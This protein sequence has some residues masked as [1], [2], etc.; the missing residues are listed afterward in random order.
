MLF[1]TRI[2][3]AVLLLSMTACSSFHR[4]QQSGYGP[5]PGQVES[6]TPNYN[7]IPMQA[8]LQQ[9]ES[10]LETTREKQQYSKILP[11]FNS[12][13]EKIEF[14]SL[15]NLDERQRWIQANKIWR[16]SQAPS[17][18]VRSLIEGGDISVGMPMDYVKKSWGEPQNVEV[19][20]NPIYKNERWRY[21]RYVSSQDGYRLE[22]RVVYFESGRVTGWETE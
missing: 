12:D 11:W 9:L 7:T 10:K 1:S 16:R 14:L 18:E 15:P 3:T 22:K 4:S 17:A 6:E 19:S 5:Q 21:S 2:T 20:G 8:R 13:E